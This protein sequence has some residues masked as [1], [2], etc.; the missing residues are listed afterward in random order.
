MN[1]VDYIYEICKDYNPILVYL[2]GSCLYKGFK[3]IEQ[4]LEQSKDIDLIVVVG[5]N[6]IVDANNL[7]YNE[8]GYS[9]DVFK[10]YENNNL[11]INDHKF[12]VKYYSYRKF[13]ALLYKCAINTI[14]LLF[15]E[16][17]FS[18]VENKTGTLFDI[19]TLLEYCNNDKLLC[20]CNN[21]LNS[22][23]DK[24]YHF[25][26]SNKQLSHCYRLHN[27][28]NCFANKKH[29]FNKEFHDTYTSIRNGNKLFN[30]DNLKICK[31]IKLDKQIDFS[32]HKRTCGYLIEGLSL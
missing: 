29:L 8:C 16:P 11:Y 24:Y 17:L 18:K 5:S 26:E 22:E 6:P 9:Y 30:I 2:S 21:Y 20:S 19:N 14:E 7:L 28:Y 3:S 25:D 15:Q 4:C 23:L 32:I 27:Y 13:L 31:P 10:H 1:S 12:D